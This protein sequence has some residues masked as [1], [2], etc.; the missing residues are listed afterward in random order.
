MSQLTSVLDSGLDSRHLLEQLY[1]E[2]SLISYEANETIPLYNDELV[3]VCRGVVQLL[4][5]HPNGDEVL[6]G[7]A[8]P[9]T[10]IGLPLTSVSPYQAITLTP[11]N[12]LRLSLAE[13][14]ASPALAAGL[15]R[16]MT[17]RLQQAEAWLASVGRRYVADRL[18]C[19]LIWLAQELG[20]P[21]PIGTRITVRLTH[22]QLAN[23][24]GT[25]RTTVTKLFNEFRLEGWLKLDKHRH[26]ILD[27]PM[28]MKQ[29]H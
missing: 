24:I 18:R 19:L 6:L 17:L 29:V 10:S 3:I 26:I 16:H 20:Q 1:Q 23:A 2:R 25:T 9:S 12:V 13:V 5:I 4:S 22:Q 21:A 28:L 27:L 14:E 15:F 7:L 11:A 8:G